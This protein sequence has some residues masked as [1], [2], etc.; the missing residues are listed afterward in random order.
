[1]RSRGD[2]AASGSAAE[3][4]AAGA[5]S[6][7]EET[8]RSEPGQL[9]ERRAEQHCSP[10]L[11]SGFE[12]A[13]LRVG[14]QLEAD[15]NGSPTKRS[16]VS[17]SETPESPR[18]VSRVDRSVVGSCPGGRGGNLDAGSGT[19]VTDL[20]TNAPPPQRP[21]SSAAPAAVAPDTSPGTVKYAARAERSCSS[22]RPVAAFLSSE[23]FFAAR[24]SAAF[25]SFAFF[26]Q[27][28][29]R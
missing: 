11:S 4:E 6:R 25:A 15:S 5:R 14:R 20:I 29:K 27:S 1:M 22:V 17:G 28:L 26:G 21:Y 23:S 3:G 10:P 9:E 7:V 2:A 24:A 8:A 13:L 16:G 12:A 19:L 18:E